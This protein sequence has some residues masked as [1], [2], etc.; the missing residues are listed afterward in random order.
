MFTKFIIKIETLREEIKSRIYNELKRKSLES[1]YSIG[2]ISLLIPG[3]FLDD[4]K[5][6]ID[7]NF[8]EN[9]FNIQAFITYN[10]ASGNNKRNSQI[11]KRF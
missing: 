6:L 9:D 3:G 7:Y 2:K 5:K 10:P 1:N 8:K 11:K 4:N